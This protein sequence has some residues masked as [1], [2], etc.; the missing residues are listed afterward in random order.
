VNSAAFVAEGR[1]HAAPGASTAEAQ[2]KVG[3]QIAEQVVLALAGE[4]VPYAVN[5]NAAAGSDA[6]R[7]LVPLAERL[8]H[9]LAGLAGGLPGC[10]PAAR[11]TGLVR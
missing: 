4:F 10:D 11:V 7:P 1:G 5:V 6:V 9:L 3:E 8:G 2:D